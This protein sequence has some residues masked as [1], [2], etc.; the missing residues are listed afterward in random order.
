MDTGDIQPPDPLILLGASRRLSIDLANLTHRLALLQSAV[1]SVL[2]NA[3]GF[4]PS[5][6]IVPDGERKVAVPVEQAER[7]Q[8]MLAALRHLM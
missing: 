3:Q 8:A 4:D 5:S 1:E 2:E 6:W 7:V